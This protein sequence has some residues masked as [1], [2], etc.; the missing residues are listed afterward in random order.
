MSR[1]KVWPAII[2]GVGDTGAGFLREFESVLPFAFRQRAV[3]WRHITHTEHEFC[4]G[5]DS[6][7]LNDTAKIRAYLKALVDTCTDCSSDAE[8]FT[9]GML[10]VRDNPVIYIVAGPDAGA[11]ETVTS[12]CEHF[13]FLAWA[14]SLGQL[15]TCVIVLAD[16]ILQL[17]EEQAEN[18]GVLATTVASLLV[19][20]LEVHGEPRP[21]SRLHCAWLLGHRNGSNVTLK[22]HAELIRLGALGV[23]HLVTTE[24]GEQLHTYHGASDDDREG[25]AVVGSFGL[26]QVGVPQEA[27]EA[28]FGGELVKDVVRVFTDAAV[29]QPVMPESANALLGGDG[30]N[31][32][33]LVISL[34]G[35]SQLSEFG[36]KIHDLKLQDTVYYADGL[37]SLIAWAE[38]AAIGE[39]AAEK[40]LEE[41]HAK[42]IQRV[43]EAMDELAKLPGGLA[44]AVLTA[45][46]VADHLHE[47]GDECE[48]LLERE[49]QRVKDLKR[50]A[51]ECIEGVRESAIELDLFRQHY[52]PAHMIAHSL[53]AIAAVVGYAVMPWLLLQLLN[54]IVGSSGL[55]WGLVW[56]SIIAG[57]IAAPLLNIGLR[58]MV[59]HLEDI[60][61]VRQSHLVLLLPI[62]P[63]LIVFCTALV[64]S[65]RL[66]S[67]DL[68]AV[69]WA[70]GLGI[71]FLLW[72]LPYV[73]KGLWQALGEAL[74][75]FVGFCAD[76]VLALVA[77]TVRLVNVV[78]ARLGKRPL[79][80]PTPYR[81]KVEEPKRIITPA[82]STRSRLGSV[83]GE[84]HWVQRQGQVAVFS[85]AIVPLFFLLAVG[86]VESF[87]SVPEA[88][89]NF[90]VGRMNEA[91]FNMFDLSVLSIVVA[92]LI[93]T[94]VL[95]VVGYNLQLRF[96]E[97]RVSNRFD[98]ATRVADQ[99]AKV[100]VQQLAL[101]LSHPWFTTAANSVKALASSAS[102]CQESFAEALAEWREESMGRSDEAR[103]MLLDS[104]NNRPRFS[105]FFSF[106]DLHKY[107]SRRLGEDLSQDQY[108]EARRELAQVLAKEAAVGTSAHWRD[109]GGGELAVD[110]AKR[111]V[112]SRVAA[113]L[114]PDLPE[115][116]L[117]D[118]EAIAYPIFE[119]YAQ[120]YWHFTA[121]VQGLRSRDMVLAP[122][123]LGL[124]K[125]RFP[126]A[127]PIENPSSAT[128]ISLM[129]F[130]YGLPLDVFPEWAY[131]NPREE[132]TG[133][134]K[135]VTESTKTPPQKVPKHLRA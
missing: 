123:Q 51:G 42:A 48:R 107:Y 100:H 21:M 57:L 17:Q 109:E 25:L 93:A 127:E 94:L 96:H 49:S 66:S 6:L 22:N 5:E 128:T 89:T 122:C 70:S 12:L 130:V 126:Q 104:A 87:R 75:S 62:L 54:P 99:L 55:V 3:V 46:T 2:L 56:A 120:P 67:G 119:N 52:L 133:A 44:S 84:V 11:A 32:R 121:A 64:D 45:Q 18:F 116:F 28:H 47:N 74:E 111:L 132:A 50:S 102:A 101:G 20:P 103:E 108:E 63:L 53:T 115:E 80:G 15:H 40:L 68:R 9:N 82:R 37:D 4:C 29:S 85:L 135:D 83:I 76:V 78:R 86:V 16:D 61:L 39:G 95:D 30:F 1:P 8:A 117:R 129:C 36:P 88:S 77:L 97:G 92:A 118:G 10:L 34:L 72:L 81:G 58:N 90:V 35:L 27:L 110:E 31:I 23:A 41:Q 91:F 26:A 33:A 112:A 124:V 59:E 79:Q 60:K 7:P 73:L 113:V 19:A 38:K 43:E 71:V 24:A 134:T 65:N 13:A 105:P 131:L 125:S 106:D 98:E 14:A 69:A 114:R